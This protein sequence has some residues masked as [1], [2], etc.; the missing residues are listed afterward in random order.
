M[1]KFL[2]ASA[3]LVSAISL[4]ACKYD[5]SADAMAQAQ[6]EDVQKRAQEEVGIYTPTNFTQKRE[7]NLIGQ[8][9]DQ[10]NL[11]TLS[12]T[13]DIY[14]KWHCVGHT[15][16]FPL[17]YATQTTSPEKVSN[18]YGTQYM[19]LPQA[20]PNGLFLP[21]QA[22][23]TWILLVNSKGVVRP[24]YIEDHVNGFFP[25]AKPNPKDIATDCD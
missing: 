11:A 14:G 16:G 22:D 5:T 13:K 21:P 8:L 17:P 15:V 9:L 20:E 10:P 7:A 6:Q 24:T 18:P 2:L 12:Y 1:K 25:D 3:L 19:T 23:G 4:G